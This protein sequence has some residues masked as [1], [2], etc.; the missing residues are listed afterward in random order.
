MEERQPDEIKEEENKLSDEILSTKVESKSEYKDYN[1]GVETKELDAGVI[2]KIPIVLKP[3]N[4][5]TAITN[6]ENNGSQPIIQF[7]S[8]ANNEVN[9]SYNIH[10]KT[11][12]SDDENESQNDS[13]SYNK[14]PRSYDQNTIFTDESR[15][16]SQLSFEKNIIIKINL[17]KNHLLTENKNRFQNTNGILNIQDYTYGLPKIEKCKIDEFYER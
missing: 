14:S 10:I 3:E 11:Q 16:Y 8:D 9:W 2:N 17:K 6:F 15:S 13:F 1:A 7:V 4:N 5:K 12:E